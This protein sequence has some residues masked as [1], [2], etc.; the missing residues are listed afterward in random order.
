MKKPIQISLW[1]LVII[2]LI[3]ACT[4]CAT[5]RYK[6]DCQ[7]VRHEKQKGGFYL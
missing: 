5:Q 4:S 6:K 7:G 3:I 1:L 2:Y